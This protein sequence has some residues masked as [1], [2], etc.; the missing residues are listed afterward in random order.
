ML[1]EAT[2]GFINHLLTAEEWPRDR[3]KPFAGQTARLELGALNLPLEISRE[4]LF[5]AG[6]K[7]APVA[8]CIKLP[9]DSPLRVLTDVSSLMAAA[10]ISGS[11]DLAETLGFVFRNLRW[12]A[13]SDLSLLVGDVAAHRLVKSGQQLLSWQQQKALNLA[14]NLTEYF[15]EENQTIARRQD[16]SSFCAEVEHVQ[17]TLAQLEN[18]VARLEASSR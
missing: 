12:D 16:I 9:A 18:R 4:G 7:G 5:K 1:L 14:A 10:H 3:L 13:E 15:T 6:G 2:L 17:E 8:V 11:V